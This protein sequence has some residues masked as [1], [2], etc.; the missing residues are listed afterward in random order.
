M[1]L[2]IPHV[3]LLCIFG[4]SVSCS[5]K[6]DE[7]E[8]VDSRISHS[9]QISYWDTLSKKFPNKD[10]WNFEF[11]DEGLPRN[12]NKQN[13]EVNKDIFAKLIGD[14]SEYTDWKEHLTFY[15]YSLNMIDSAEV[16]VF[17]R[18]TEF[19][20][21]TYSV[22]LLK[23]DE[24]GKFMKLATLAEYWA[25]AECTGITISTVYLEDKIIQS[26]SVRRCYNAA[27]ENE[28]SVDSVRTTMSFNNLDFRL[29]RT[30]SLNKKNGC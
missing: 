27:C 28:E 8:H 5:N 4:L 15:F 10:L 24:K 13:T 14:V 2:Y 16:A 21:T 7:K 18:Q 19:D 6:G 1:K 22:D 12:F 26:L 20:G 11:D 23:L 3:I 25:I 9:R 30:D 29:I 17:V